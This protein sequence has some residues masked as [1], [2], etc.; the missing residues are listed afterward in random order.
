MTGKK[1]TMKGGIFGITPSQPKYYPET[2]TN[3]TFNELY[4]KL[5][6]ENQGLVTDFLNK[7]R[8]EQRLEK[9]LNILEYKLKQPDIDV[10]SFAKFYNYFKEIHNK[11]KN[12]TIIRELSDYV[13]E[14]YNNVI[15]ELEAK[16]QKFIDNGLLGEKN[17]KNIP[18]QLSNNQLLLSTM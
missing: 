13:K 18:N 3:N 6:R 2:V 9:F 1:K 12:T 16:K 10:K 11:Y 5:T 15:K 4:T 17:K 8:S 7:K 14:L